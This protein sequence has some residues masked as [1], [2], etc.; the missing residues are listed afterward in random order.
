[1]DRSSKWASHDGLRN[2]ETFGSP[3][4]D[5]LGHTRTVVLI[6]CTGLSVVAPR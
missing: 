3:S 4:S 6:W 5:G 1:M 2:A